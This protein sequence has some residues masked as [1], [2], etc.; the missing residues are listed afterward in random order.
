MA[1]N[2]GLVRMRV[3]LE[4]GSYYCNPIKIFNLFFK[5]SV[6]ISLLRDWKRNVVKIQQTLYLN[7][8]TSSPFKL[9]GEGRKVQN[10][11]MEL[12]LYNWI[13]SLRFQHLRIFYD[14]FFSKCKI[15]IFTCAHLNG[16][17]FKLRL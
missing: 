7:E 14:N 6:K 13:L 16:N 9:K 12:K 15:C 17:P 5:N 4:G 10:E 1:A 11:V 2:A 3:S 8:K